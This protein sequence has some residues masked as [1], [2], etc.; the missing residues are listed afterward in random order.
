MFNNKVALFQEKATTKEEALKL[1]SDALAE[2]ASPRQSVLVIGFCT[3]YNFL[4][5]KR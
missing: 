4:S 2:K 3:L 5:V 1:L